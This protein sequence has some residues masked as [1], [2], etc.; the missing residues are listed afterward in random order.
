MPLGRVPP[1]KGCAVWVALKPKA[2][3]RP[4]AEIFENESAIPGGEDNLNDEGRGVQAQ[5]AKENYALRG[6]P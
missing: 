6:R 2:G 4:F 1:Y 5:Q 3:A